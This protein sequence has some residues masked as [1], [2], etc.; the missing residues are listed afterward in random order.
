MA[1]EKLE[2]APPL[3]AGA[4][5]LLIDTPDIEILLPVKLRWN[6]YSGFREIENVSAD[7]R[8]ERPSGFSDLPEK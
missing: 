1:V 3:E 6:P 7:Q 2:M 5:I 4:A 8:P